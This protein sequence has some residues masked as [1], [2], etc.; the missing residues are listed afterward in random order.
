VQLAFLLGKR[1]LAHQQNH[2]SN[3]TYLSTKRNWMVV[4]LPEQEGCFSDAINIRQ[5]LD[6]TCKTR[7]TT[8]VNT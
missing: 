8:T 2:S 3:N 7:K 6:A 4:C 1:Q 5:T